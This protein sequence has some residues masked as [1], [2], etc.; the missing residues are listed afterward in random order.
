MNDGTD[1]GDTSL[2][3]VG[4]WRTG[5]GDDARAMRGKLQHV[6]SGAVMYFT[7]LSSLTQVLERMIEQESHTIT[8]DPER[9][10][11]VNYDTTQK[12]NQSMNEILSGREISGQPPLRAIGT[13]ASENGEASGSGGAQLQDLLTGGTGAGRLRARKVKGKG[14]RGKG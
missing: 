14:I 7:E 4:I 1:T 10:K 8:R 3:L 9:P 5:P 2:Y 6:V 12:E 11:D 13:E